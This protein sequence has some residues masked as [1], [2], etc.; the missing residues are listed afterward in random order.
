MLMNSIADGQCGLPV[1]K[2]A[3]GCRWDTVLVLVKLAKD[4]ERNVLVVRQKQI[5]VVILAKKEVIAI[6]NKFISV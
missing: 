4:Q 5:H 1:V 6:V 2:I 3:M